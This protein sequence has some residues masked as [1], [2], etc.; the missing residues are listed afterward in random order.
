VPFGLARQADEDFALASTL[1]AE[2]SHDFLKTLMQFI[3]LRAQG[4]GGFGAL[5]ADARD[6][7]KAFFWAL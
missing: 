5:L 7:M 2:A 3:C 1:T 6:D 4:C